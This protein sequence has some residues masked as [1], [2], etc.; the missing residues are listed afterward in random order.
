MK[1]Y[2]IIDNGHGDDTAGK[3]SPDGR[4]HEWEWT[5]MA[6]RRLM[7]EL[8]GRGM[9]TQLLVPEDHDVDLRTRCRRAN[10]I[11]R[12]SPEAVLLSLHSNASGD[13]TAWGDASGWSAWVAPGASRASRRLA[14]L[15]SLEASRRNLFGNRHTPAVGYWE[16]GLYICRNTLCPT[17]LTENMF[18]DHRG[19]V[20]FLLSDEGLDEIVQLHADAIERYYED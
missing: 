18:H 19:N 15:L 7:L 12:Y 11:Y 3:C 13:G 8:K 9:T 20:D 5:R 6:A 2:V 17:V 4:Y 10:E 1:T 14:G 16:R